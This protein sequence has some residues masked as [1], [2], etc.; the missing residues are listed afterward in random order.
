A[1]PVQGCPG[2]GRAVGRVARRAGAS[3]G[4]DRAGLHV[5][6]A[7]DV[8]ADVADV[9][10][11]LWT[12]LDAVRLLELRL[13]RRTAVAAVARLARARD[14]GEEA[15]LHLDLAHGVV[16]HVDDVEIARGVEADFVRLV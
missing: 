10:V 15:G 9:E 6:P 13:R 8:V 1:R 16:D 3:E 12:E 2:D 5:D 11:A 7:D 4:G 14:G